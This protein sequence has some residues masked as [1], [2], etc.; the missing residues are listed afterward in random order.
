MS[1]VFTERSGVDCAPIS[2]M[3]PLS[4]TSIS[5]SG[6]AMPSTPASAREPRRYVDVGRNEALT[7]PYEQP[8]WNIVFWTLVGVLVLGQFAV[9]LRSGLTRSGQRAEKPWSLVVVV[10]AVLGGMVGGIELANWN[11]AAVGAGRSTLFALGLVLMALGI[12]V[13]QWAILVL[14]RFFTGDVRL[15]PG[16]TIVDRGPYRWVRHPSYTGLIVFFLGVGLALSDWASL[17][18]LALVPTAGLLVRIRSEESALFVGLGEDYRRYA[19][20][21]RRLIPG[22]W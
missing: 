18:T 3:T 20:T 1:D 11:A 13:R 9:R 17:A 10:A 8:G 21:R 22:V 6:Y 2:H 15:H 12:L 5:I 7:P 16:Q 19:A 14:G 4:T